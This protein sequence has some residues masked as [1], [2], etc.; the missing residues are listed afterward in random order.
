MLVF[1]MLCQLEQDLVSILGSIMEKE[2]RKY[3]SVV[4]VTMIMSDVMP[5]NRSVK[6]VGRSKV[7]NCYEQ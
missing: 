7:I 6:F 1:I 4:I 3:L 2:M 5:C